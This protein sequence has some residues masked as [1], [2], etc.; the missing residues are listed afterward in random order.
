MLDAALVLPSN[1]SVRAAVEAGAGIAL[2]S[3]LI[4]SPAIAAGRLHTGV[5]EFAPRPR[6]RYRSKTADMLLE[7]IGPRQLS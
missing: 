1:E 6:E 7:L 4:V 3:S 2:L 5:I